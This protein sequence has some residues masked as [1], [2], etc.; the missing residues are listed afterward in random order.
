MAKLGKRNPAP[1]AKHSVGKV[2]SDRWKKR[3]PLSNS[4]TQKRQKFDETI[5]I[6]DELVLTPSRDQMVA[7][8]VGLPRTAPANPFAV[9][10]ILHVPQR[11]DERLKQ[12]VRICGAEDLLKPFQFFGN[13]NRLDRCNFLRPSLT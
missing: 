10:V 12:L 7:A 9:A 13:D 11:L 5:E 1:H 2:R 8:F 4:R 3:Y 6:V